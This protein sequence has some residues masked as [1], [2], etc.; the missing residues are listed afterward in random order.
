MTVSTQQVKSVLLSICIPTHDGRANLLS[1]LLASIFGQLDVE[2]ASLVEVC[3]SDNGSQDNT[4]EVIS[5][6]K[7]HSRCAIDYH[8]Y[9]KNEGL[10]NFQH[11]IDMANGDYCWM[12]G[13]DD[14]LPPGSIRSIVEII[15]KN[16]N[17]AGFTV[18]KLNFN[19]D[20]TALI[21]P[22][23]DI[24]LPSDW[25]T[26]RFIFGFDTIFLEMCFLFSFISAHVLKKVEWDLA[27]EEIGWN[28]FERMRH[29]AFSSVLAKITKKS[30]KWLWI[31]DFLV[32][33]R[34]GNSCL[35]EDFGDLGFAIQCTADMQSFVDLMLSDVS[36]AKRVKY[37]I[38]KK[39]FLLYWNPIL[40][41]KYK[42]AGKTQFSS[43]LQML[44]F[45]VKSFGRVPLFWLTSFFVLSLPGFLAPSLQA[46]ATRMLH[47]VRRKQLEQARSLAGPTLDQTA[48]AVLTLAGSVKLDA[49][50]AKSPR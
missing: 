8:R 45:C 47:I 27:F 38:Q 12:I 22:D 50:P 19:V 28:T 42:S 10:R 44:R 18:N 6:A 37:R 46:L 13:S 48:S 29:F 14:L 5:Q 41:L 36:N 9:D 21:G 49:M 32:T 35:V 40:I 34:L 1:E 23:N 4:P 39:L 26:R 20:Y 31:P 43:D 25:S 3:I 16:R 33:Q 7:S 2:L 15:G 17:I 30:D 11:V 24:V